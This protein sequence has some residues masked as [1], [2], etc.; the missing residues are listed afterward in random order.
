MSRRTLLLLTFAFIVTLGV[1][2]L[3]HRE[4]PPPELKAGWFAAGAPLI[5][6]A[7]IEDNLHTIVLRS[8]SATT[9]MEMGNDEWGIVERDGFPVN[10][11]QLR[12]FIRDLLDLE[13]AEAQ[14]AGPSQYPRLGLEDPDDTQPP[15]SNETP[16][17]VTLKN[18]EGAP[19]AELVFGTTTTLSGPMAAGHGGGRFA[20]IPGNENQ[21]LLVANPLDR[22]SATPAQWID[23]RMPRPTHIVSAT[24]EAAD[25]PA[26]G[27]TLVRD[28]PDKEWELEAPEMPDG[29]IL[30]QSKANSAN[31]VW[32]TLRPN[33]ILPTVDQDALDEIEPSHHARIK[34]ADGIVYQYTITPFDGHK[35]SGSQYALQIDVNGEWQ[36]PAE[37]ET[38]NGQPTQDWLD[39]LSA[40]QKGARF[41]YLVPANALENLLTP[42]DDLLEEA[43]EDNTDNSEE[44]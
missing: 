11:S 10:F 38:D 19:L 20:R 41:T 1:V 17:A 35:T 8:P 6:P 12:D 33:D 40:A 44:G 36:P 15:A 25:A 14:M 5:D 39:K 21:V 27:W 7:V 30:S 23:P 43:A 34:T 24:L 26:D 2:V 22:Y 28:A 42:M 37:E 16:L 4:T 31:N 29:K 32:A 9:S 3:I 18:A 13:V